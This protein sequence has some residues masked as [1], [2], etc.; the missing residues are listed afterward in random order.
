[1]GDLV[2]IPEQRQPT[3][4]TDKYQVRWNP[5]MDAHKGKTA[6][7]TKVDTDRT[8][9]LDLSD[10]WWAMDWLERAVEP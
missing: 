9:V 4:H 2:K 7:V 1:V 3:F 6:T 5:E 8:V 10:W